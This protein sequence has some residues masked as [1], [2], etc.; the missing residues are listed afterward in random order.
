MK[1][2][3]TALAACLVAGFVV[4]QSVTSAN[5][6]GY[7]T[8]TVTGGGQNI[9]GINFEAVGGGASTFQTVNGNKSFSD[10]DFLYQ[11]DGSIGTFGGGYSWD[12]GGSTWYDVA[13]DD[14]GDPV[15]SAGSGF[16]LICAASESITVAGQVPVS[17]T[18]LVI[19]GSSQYIVA[20]PVPTGMDLN[21]TA[22]TWT[23]ISDGDFIYVWD[24]SS[25]G[26][27]YS[28]DAGGSVWY[29]VAADDVASGVKVQQGQG[30]WLINANQVTL[31]ATY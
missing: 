19:P 6:V 29:D 9:V 27:G 1:K 8:A 25:F 14:V 21:D 16:W 22:F 17:G 31:Q 13:A 11:W 4:A 2:L 10:G 20:N 18:Q 23:G 15:V 7:N 5:I 26:G 3:M 28:W 12:A 30:F 24:G